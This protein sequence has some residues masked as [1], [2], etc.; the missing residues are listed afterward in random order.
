MKA[1]I[2][3]IT[4][5]TVAVLSLLLAPVIIIICILTQDKDPLE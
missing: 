5:Y 3:K 2:A 4:G 1:I